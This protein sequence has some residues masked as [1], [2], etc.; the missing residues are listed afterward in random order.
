MTTCGEEDQAGEDRSGH[1]RGRDREFNGGAGQERPQPS[2]KRRRSSSSGLRM[3][4]ADEE[5]AEEAADG[6]LVD[7]IVRTFWQRGSAKAMA[8]PRPRGIPDV[9]PWRRP[10]SGSKGIPSGG[11]RPKGLPLKAA[12][13][14][15]PRPTA[16]LRPRYHSYTSAYHLVLAEMAEDQALARPSRRPRESED[17]SE[18]E[19]ERREEADAAP[20]DDSEDLGERERV[21]LPDRWQQENHVP[22]LIESDTPAANLGHDE[23]R[24][25]V[26]YLERRQRQERH[27][28]LSTPMAA[29][30]VAPG[31]N[32]TGSTSRRKRRR[33][34]PIGGTAASSGVVGAKRAT[35]CPPAARRSAST[36]ENRSVAGRRHLVVRERAAPI[37]LPPPLSGATAV[38]HGVADEPPMELAG[39][40]IGASPKRSAA[41]QRRQDQRGAA[42]DS[43]P[44]TPGVGLSRKPPPP[45]SGVLG[46]V[47]G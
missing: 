24:H 26:G 18:T 22:S 2:R 40:V 19:Q 45:L 25:G 35:N 12:A 6:T 30:L 5:A 9:A 20:G 28:R 41:G 16:A 23:D 44:T 10:P 11:G 39:R 46:A 7:N 4:R 31:S 29:S 1:S 37:G 33:T 34:H 8:R 14:W 43:G 38:T 42:K 36:V 13:K 27:E 47:T 21:A 15:K 17:E 3:T 32:C